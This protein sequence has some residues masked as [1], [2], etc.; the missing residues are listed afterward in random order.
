MYKSRSV[1]I[2]AAAVV[3]TA[4]AAVLPLST[5]TPPA[6]AAGGDG[7]R[8]IPRV[9]AVNEVQYGMTYADWSAAWWQWAYSLPASENPWFDETGCLNGANGQSGPVWFLTGVV[10]ASGI[11]VRD[12]TVPHG[13]ALF[14]PI[15]NFENDNVCPPQNLTI[16]QLRQAAAAAEDSATALACEVDGRPIRNLQSFRVQSPTFDITFPDGNVFQFFGC[17]VPPGTYGPFVSDGY[18]L[19]L[20]PLSAGQH[21]IHFH[22]HV[23]VPFSFTLDITYHL[24]VTG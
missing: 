3:L 7:D 2:L 5:A 22:G 9:L 23:E 21:T 12:C 8:C 1:F 13:K 14:F 19:M 16:A 6:L 11:A 24:T 20:E 4:V 15:L 10:N 18:W 17:D